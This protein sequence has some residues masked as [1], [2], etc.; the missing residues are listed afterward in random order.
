[1]SSHQKFIV[2]NDSRI[3]V[4][5]SWAVPDKYRN[6]ITFIPTQSV[7]L[8]NEEANIVAAF[9]PL[10]KKEYQINVP[11]FTS[12]LFDQVKNSVG[13]FNPG[14]GLGQKAP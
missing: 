13:F 12:F 3:P 9:T 1:M 7:L 6:E 4:E 14:S 10:K 2:K 11:L 8:P 5:Y